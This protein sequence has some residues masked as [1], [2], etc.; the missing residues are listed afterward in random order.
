MYKKMWGG[1]LLLLTKS[2][3]TLL[4]VFMTIA[5]LYSGII[6]WNR[7]KEVEDYSRIIWAVLSW[8]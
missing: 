2:I 5:L 3:A 1:E 6:L 8:V 7:R 4:F